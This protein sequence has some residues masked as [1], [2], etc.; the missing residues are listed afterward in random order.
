MDYKYISSISFLALCLALVHSDVLATN[1][2][3]QAGVW[4]GVDI[5][6]GNVKTSIEGDNENE[7]AHYLSFKALYRLDPHYLVGFELSGWTLESGNLWNPSKGEGIS[8]AFVVTQFYPK[9]DSGLFLKAGGGYASHW[10]NRSGETRRRS[11]LGITFGGGYDYPV[12]DDWV[13]T[14][15]MA[16][17]I[18]ETDNED[19]E[20]WALGIGLANRF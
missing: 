11:G 8:Q 12:Q 14:P 7:S 2:S 1:E 17:S 16:F 5:G 20:A 10:N 18:A 13:L 19:H 6:G 4:V 3:D 9:V 15:F